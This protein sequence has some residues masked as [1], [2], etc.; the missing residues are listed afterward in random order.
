MCLDR[1]VLI[2]LDA[3]AVDVL[4]FSAYLF[5]R[6]LPSPWPLAACPPPALL[7]SRRGQTPDMATAR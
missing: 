6:T 2:G 1:K 3:V 7:E 4:S 5:G